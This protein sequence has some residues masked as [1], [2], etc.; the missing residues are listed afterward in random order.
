VLL[1]R[2]VYYKWARDA[3]AVS[4]REDCGLKARAALLFDA[5]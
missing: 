5:L 2:N 3:A 4:L 1:N